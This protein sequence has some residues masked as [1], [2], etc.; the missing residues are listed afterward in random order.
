MGLWRR[1]GV[2]IHSVNLDWPIKS[3]WSI[4]QRM[5]DARR[6]VAAV[7]PDLIHIHHIGPALLVRTALGNSGPARVFQ[8][9]GPLHLEHALFRQ[10]ELGTATAL[11][12]WIATSQCI[13][14]LYQAAG[15]SERRVFLSYHGTDVETFHTVRTRMLRRRLQ[16]PADAFL[17][18][19]I[20]Y[21]YP[22]K[23]YLGQFV[24]LKAHEDLIEGIAGIIRSHPNAIGVLIG[25][26][27]GRRGGYERRLRRM[28][29]S[30]GRGRIFM[31]GYF[32]REE[33]QAALGDFDC[34][35]HV[36]ISENCGGVVEPLLAAVPTIASR[37]GGLP[38]VV[39]EGVTGRIVSPRRPHEL[40]ATIREIMARPAEHLAMAKRGRALALKM[41]DIRRTAAEILGIYRHILEGVDVAAQFDSVAFAQAVT[42]EHCD[43]RVPGE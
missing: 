16:L 20:N 9:A 24:G 7:K 21:I 35:V 34:A 18:G 15:I 36:P 13:R 42:E 19:N 39:I 28:A 5:Q 33:V 41:F 1:A 4:R 32:D 8:V 43:A 25:S 31:P 23:Y 10:W 2:N 14:R 17:I 37:V 29:R 6:L 22:P 11:D 40:T 3:P 27:W 26:T 12:S 38:E 30:I